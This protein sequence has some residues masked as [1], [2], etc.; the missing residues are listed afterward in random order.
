MSAG[1]TITVGI[2][3]YR[4]RYNAS[5]ARNCYAPVPGTRFR[6]LP[7]LP[8]D[9]VPRIGPTFNAAYVPIAPLSCDLMH[10]WNRINLGPRPW[11]VTYESVL[12]RLFNVEPR[13]WRASVLR[14]RLLD[15]RCRF[16]IAASEFARRFFLNSLDDREEEAV[17]GK[18]H[19]VYPYQESVDREPI[20]P[21]GGDE[22]LAV[23]FVGGDFF[24]KGG[25]AVLSAI[26]RLGASLDVRAT[27]VSPAAHGDYAVPRT[28]S[29]I[30]QV[31]RRLDANERIT[32]Y[33]SLPNDRVLQLMDDSHIGLL[34]T[35]ADTFGYSLLEAM[36]RGLPI[37]GTTVQAGSEIADPSVGWSIDAATLPN[38]YWTGMGSRDAYPNALASLTEGLCGVLTAVRERPDVLA[39]KSR[40]ALRRVA[41]RFGSE[42]TVQA[43]EIYKAA[44]PTSP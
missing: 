2:D 35:L 22:P 1:G 18:L 37:V 16:V 24:R 5:A 26:E 20:R 6:R 17:A 43:A 44:L 25:E 27:V 30:E 21:P 13:G 41:E 10:L 3:E 29:E 4:N 19:R 9:K 14:R 42:R 36:S 32:W 11:G 23:F 12:P 7:R 39:A 40:E 33:P 34:P 31:R 15:D 38:G 28:D 8:L